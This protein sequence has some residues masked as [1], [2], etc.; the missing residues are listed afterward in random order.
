[1][2]VLGYNHEKNSKN[3]I[4]KDENQPTLGGKY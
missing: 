4:E 3:I 2:Q 1:M